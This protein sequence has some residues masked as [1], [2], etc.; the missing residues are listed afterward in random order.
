MKKSVILLLYE[1]MKEN[2]KIRENHKPV[3]F[4]EMTKINQ[5][6]IDELMK[7]SIV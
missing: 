2:I 7:I 4:E 5:E 6:K 1:K 3:I